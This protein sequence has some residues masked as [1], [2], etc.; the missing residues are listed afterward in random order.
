MHTRSITLAL[1]LLAFVS[2]VEAQGTTRIVDARGGAGVF[3]DIQAAIDASA[4]SGDTI[5]V[6]K[7]DYSGFRL[8][9][10][11]VTILAEGGA[12]VARGTL[13]SVIVS[14]SPAGSRSIIQGLTFDATVRSQIAVIGNPGELVLDRVVMSG[15]MLLCDFTHANLVHIENCK[16]QG[17]LMF[18]SGTTGVIVGSQIRGVT[19]GLN[20]ARKQ[21]PTI[22]ANGARGRTLYIAATSIVGANA[23]SSA[24]FPGAAIEANGQG[25]IVI[26]GGSKDVIAAGKGILP[27]S[28]IEDPFSGTGEIVLDLRVP[29][30]GNGMAPGLAWHGKVTQGSDATLTS[31]VAS[32]AS[33]LTLDVVSE[34][35]F[36]HALLVGTPVPPT[37]VGAFG[38]L[39]LAAF[40]AVAVGRG[41]PVQ[42]KIAIPNDL[43]L[44]GVVVAWQ[45]LGSV[46]QRALRLSN[47]SIT[48]V[49]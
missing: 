36:G 46:P 21:N 16:M 33:T 17:T 34:S 40:V 45:T 20:T 25:R 8:H 37:E 32:I 10:K 23:V 49:R 18:Q 4:S 35:Q 9:K 12:R 44:R 14:A 24:D 41:T 7:G 29:V 3:L 30:Q 27:R 28:A 15:Q 1:S 19:H 11:T 42:H 43:K 13:Q 6:R 26:R 38:E 2:S 5:L 47:V 48:T 39:G 31:G 22:R